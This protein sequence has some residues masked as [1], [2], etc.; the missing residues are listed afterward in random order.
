MFHNK[1]IL[2]IITKANET[3]NYFPSWK[4]CNAYKREPMKNYKRGLECQS[5]ANCD[6]MNGNNYEKGCP[7]K[8]HVIWQPEWKSEWKSE[9]E[10]A[11]FHPSWNNHTALC[12]K[13][14]SPLD[15]I[16]KTTFKI[17]WFPGLVKKITVSASGDG[18]RVSSF[19]SSSSVDS[20]SVFYR[21]RKT[22]DA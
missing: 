8:L 17:P 11:K 9:R 13:T 12:M 18:L 19:S 15:N 2:A 21:N 3:L 5:G 1:I 7:W 4:Y 6:W 10:V 14:N 16:S 20:A 22:C